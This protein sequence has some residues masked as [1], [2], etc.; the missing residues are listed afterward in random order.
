VAALEVVAN[1]IR[2]VS[3][4]TPVNRDTFRIDHPPSLVLPALFLGIGSNVFVSHVD[5]MPK[6][7]VVAENFDGVECRVCFDYDPD[8]HAPADL[9][10]PCPPSASGGVEHG[11]ITQVEVVELA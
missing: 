11:K 1:R 4:L 3:V 9:N 7:W 10:E 5:R 2:E 6:L 8:R